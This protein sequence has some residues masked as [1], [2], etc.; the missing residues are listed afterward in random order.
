MIETDFHRS[1]FANG[2]ELA[3]GLA[4]WTADHLRKAI[5]ARGAALLIVSGGKSPARF[6]ELLSNLDLDWPRVTIT[7][8]DE[9]RVADDSPRSNARL[10][11]EKLLQ[12][13]AQAASFTPLADVRLPADRELAAASARIANLPSPADVVVLGMGDDGHTASWFPGA[14]GL[15]EAI[16]PGARQLVAPIVAARCARTAPHPHRASALARKGDRARDRGREKARHFRGG[17]RAR[18]RGGD[19]HSRRAAPR[20]RSAHCVQRQ[21]GLSRTDREPSDMLHKA[22]GRCPHAFTNGQLA[23]VQRTKSVLR[24]DRRDEL[25]IVPI[26]LRLG[27]SLRLVEVHRMELAPV[28]ADHSL[29]EQRIVGRDRLHGVDELD[30]VVGALGRAIAFMRCSVPAYMPACMSLGIIFLG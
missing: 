23:L 3:H 20:S 7:L 13:R 6:F 22:R 4:D 21:A 11:R 27:G 2:E 14:E 24:L 28:D 12:N 25:E 29:A 1:E 17:A 16:D 8:A 19:A 10:V 30:A 15:A 5:A 9:R 18:P 26:V